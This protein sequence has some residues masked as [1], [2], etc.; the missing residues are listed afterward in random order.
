MSNFTKLKYNYQAMNDI[1]NFK[2][3]QEVEPNFCQQPLPEES[4]LIDSV[5]DLEAFLSQ[6][7]AVLVDVRNPDETP[8]ISRFPVLEL[9]LPQLPTLCEQLLPYQHIC[10]VCVAGVRS[11]KALNFVKEQLPNKDLKSFKSGFAP[12]A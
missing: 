4:L 5:E 3:T 10:F 1:Q 6:P 12:L 8:K 11:M 9:P 7:N 2:K